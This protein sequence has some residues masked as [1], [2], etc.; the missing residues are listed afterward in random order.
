MGVFEKLRELYSENQ[1]KNLVLFVGAGISSYYAKVD[2]GKFPSWE[3]LIEYLSMDDAN[4]DCDFLRVAQVYEDNHSR[5]EL[6]DCVKNAFPNKY[7]YGEIHEAILNLTP[8]HIITTNYDDLLERAMRYKQL[9]V[10]YH[11]VSKDDSLPESNIKQNFLLK[12]HGDFVENNIVLTEHDYND[13]EKNF[14]LMLSLIKFIFSK[15]KVVFIGFSLTD[16]NFTKILHLVSSILDTKAIKHVAILHDDITESERRYFDKKSVDII[17]RNEIISEILA[18]EANKEKYLLETLSFLKIGFLR[19]SYSID[20]RLGVFRDDLRYLQCF[21]YITPEMVNLFLKNT[22][23]SFNNTTLPEVNSKNQKDKKDVRYSWICNIYQTDNFLDGKPKFNLALI[24]LDKTED[25]QYKKLSRDY[26]DDFARLLLMSNI[27]SIGNTSLSHQESSVF[28]LYDDTKMNPKADYWLT[29]KIDQTGEV[30]EEVDKSFEPN[31]PFY[32]YLILDKNLFYTDY[33]YGD[34]NNAYKKCKLAICDDNAIGN[35]LKYFRLYFLR[36]NRAVDSFEEFEQGMAGTHLYIFDSLDKYSQ[37]IAAHIHRLDFIQNYFDFITDFE[38]GWREFLDKNEREYR[39]GF[40]RKTLY[41]ISF[42]IA[43]SRLLKFTILN[44]LPIVEN[45]IFQKSIHKSNILYLNSFLE[46]QDNES[47]SNWMLIGFLLDKN[48]KETRIELINFHRKH[49]SEE[50]VYKIDKRYIKALFI[51]NLSKL[52]SESNKH[53]HLCF[54]NV[55][56]LISICA[57]EEDTFLL[58]LRLFYL[59]IKKDIKNIEFYSEQL[60]IAYI[61]YKEHNQLSIAV[62]DKMVKIFNLYIECKLDYKS[63]DDTKF[64][65]FTFYVEGDFSQKNARIVEKLRSLEKLDCKNIDLFLRLLKIMGYEAID[66]KNIIGWLEK[67]FNDQFYVSYDVLNDCLNKIENSVVVLKSHFNVDLGVIKIEE[68]YC[69]KLRGNKTT[70]GKYN[71]LGWLLFLMDKNVLSNEFNKQISD[72]SILTS[73]NESL[74]RISNFDLSRFSLSIFDEFDKSEF[75]MVELIIRTDNLSLIKNA[76]DNP[77][78]N[79]NSEYFLKMFKY[80]FSKDVLLNGHRD[81]LIEILDWF[82]ESSH[83]N[84]TL[85]IRQIIL[86]CQD[87]SVENLRSILICIL[88]PSNTMR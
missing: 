64:A 83:K 10:R 13:Y 14:P 18:P 56:Y 45:G 73:F 74:Q 51:K 32:K 26:S 70:L 50:R 11:V 78:C 80:L 36:N 53:R 9:D 39:S 3:E 85:S 41:R 82:K 40:D 81:A 47:I 15:Y 54:A 69:G 58:I 38:V 62:K 44:S 61:N 6:I 24:M 84:L 49:L 59:I 42:Y 33:L 46:S 31:S 87:L 72:D 17:S 35:Y 37:D 75:M 5:R 66:L 68:H 7:E 19:S 21:E 29:Y 30:F 25:G 27:A 8:V 22:Y 2:G 52:S 48:T 67:E 79:K 76:F 23:L 43:Y 63:F 4:K 20:K 28:D 65:N 34:R 1:R 86:N 88:E 55:M 60:D 12:A 71:A 57:K 77:N 16:Q